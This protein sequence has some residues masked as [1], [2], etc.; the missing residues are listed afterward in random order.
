MGKVVTCLFELDVH[1]HDRQFENFSYLHYIFIERALQCDILFVFIDVNN[2]IIRLENKTV[3]TPPTV[4]ISKNMTECALSFLMT[5]LV[6]LDSRICQM[7]TRKGDS[8]RKKTVNVMLKWRSV[9]MMKKTSHRWLQC[10]KWF[11]RYPISKSGIGAK[12]TS[13]FC[14]FSASS[15]LRYGL[16]DAILQANDRMKMQCLRNL[17]FDLFEIL[18]A[19]R[20]KGISLDFK[21]RC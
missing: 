18:Q 21:F 19:V 16:T 4:P 12:W 14:R 9:K 2:N 20:S 5:G 13:P 8:D 3:T 15:L 17:S 11:S 1:N 10:V 7:N 6:G